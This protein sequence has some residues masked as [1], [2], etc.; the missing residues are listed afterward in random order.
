MSRDPKANPRSIELR[1][2]KARGHILLPGD[3]K[4]GCSLNEISDV[5]ATLILEEPHEL[6]PEFMLELEGQL[7][8]QRQCRLVAQNGKAV[9]VSFPFR[10]PQPHKRIGYV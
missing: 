4:L 1:T 8:V 7:I 5:A 2:F 9:S 3:V 6:P 10:T